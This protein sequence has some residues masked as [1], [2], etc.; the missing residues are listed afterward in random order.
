[1]LFVI[2]KREGHATNLAIATTYV[3]IY[4]RF[5][6]PTYKIL[7]SFTLTLEVEKRTEKHYS[8]FTV[9]DCT[10]FITS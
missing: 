1:M 10:R 4:C 7:L 5:A 9:S 6:I 8:R 2:G 3:W